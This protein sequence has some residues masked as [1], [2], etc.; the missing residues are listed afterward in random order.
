MIGK[1]KQV[2]PV[3]LKDDLQPVQESSTSTPKAKV[4][5]VPMANTLMDVRDKMA[6]MRA[7]RAK[8]QA[9]K[10]AVDAE[11]AAVV[12]EDPHPLARLR[13]RNKMK[14]KE[15]VMPTPTAA[16]TVMPKD[17]SRQ[18]TR[19]EK[20]QPGSSISIGKS[21]NIGK[22]Y[23]E[24][25]FYNQGEGTPH[26]L[27]NRIL[28]RHEAEAKLDTSRIT[29]DINRPTFPP[30]PYDYGFEWFF[31]QEH[32]FVLPY[33]IQQESEGGILDGKRKPAP[34]QWIRNSE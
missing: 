6:L 11:K 3:S 4:K 1:A 27:V 18:S 2:V 17:I 32:D 9:E 22:T 16:P 10:K 20:R 19:V 30:L 12:Q 23:M 24:A 14:E 7:A 13:D 5:L 15:E 31:G 28:Q 34:F 25:G 33:N 8:K 26:K 21:T 29:L